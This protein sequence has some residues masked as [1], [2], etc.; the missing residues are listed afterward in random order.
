MS[1]KVVLNYT[2]TDIVDLNKLKPDEKLDNYTKVNDILKRINELPLFIDD[3]G[4]E[5]FEVIH[6]GQ[7]IHPIHSLFMVRH[8]TNKR[9]MFVS[10][11]L[12]PVKVGNRYGARIRDR[13]REMF[14]IYSLK[15]ESWRK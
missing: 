2:A 5:E 7:K 11:N 4:V 13:V 3:V 10:T 12:G 1:G 15:G 6:F 14:N 9:L 8:S